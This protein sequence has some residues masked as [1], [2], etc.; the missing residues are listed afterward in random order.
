MR[1]R[2]KKQGAA[3]YDKLSYPARF[4]RYHELILDECTY[5]L[6]LDG[7]PKFLQSHSN[8]WPQPQEWLKLSRAGDWAYYSAMGYRDL[9]GLTG[10]YYYPHLA[11]TSNPI[12]DTNPL[13]S[14][15]VRELLAGH[16][17]RCA[18]AATLAAS[19]ALPAEQRQIL[20]LFSIWSTGRIKG[21]ATELHRIIKARVPVLPPDCRH[22]DYD[23]VPLMI[24]EGCQANCSFCRIKTT[25]GFHLRDRN[26]ITA[27]L[28][29]LQ[30]WLGL[31]RSNHAGLFLGQHDALGGGTQPI[32]D[33][34]ELA[35]NMLPPSQHLAPFSI[36]LFGSVPSL[37]A[38]SDTELHYLNTL[39]GRVYIN[40]G[41][42]SFDQ[43]T[44]E[45]IGK[46]VNAEEN[47][48]TFRRICKLNQR[49][50]NLN[51]SVNIIAGDMAGPNHLQATRTVLEEIYGFD[52]HTTIYLSPLM[53]NF[54]RSDFLS[55]LRSLKSLRKLDIY[56]YLIQRL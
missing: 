42:E 50:T 41:L 49:H 40:I 30:D 16:D 17:D 1:V 2:T 15:V 18:Q 10:E 20:K 23:V 11:Y 27:Q 9:Y 8:T 4:G 45:N 6:A 47:K 44:L 46:P 54:N 21:L 24:S 56:P 5:H 28:N 14:R 51:I 29:D 26:E 22:V 43:Q 55:D 53:S 3:R 38:V 52:P 39:P 35:M 13:Q 25:G 36:F 12:Y 19:K 34:V 37:M 33:A 48:E 32:L 7:F 31:E